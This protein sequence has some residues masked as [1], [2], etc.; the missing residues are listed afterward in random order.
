MDE[1]NLALKLK[2]EDMIMKIKV[3]KP[4][5][6]KDMI[7]NFIGNLLVTGGDIANN[8]IMVLTKDSLYLAAIGHVAIGYAEEVRSV[9]KIFL[10][11]IEEFKVYDKDTTEIIEIKS[12]QGNISF[13]RDNSKGDN[14]ALALS[15]VIDDLK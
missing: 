2:D 12:K 13:T 5:T 9:N 11:D 14:L 7:N 6:T 10:E 3:S 8:I 1:L 4:V 15:K